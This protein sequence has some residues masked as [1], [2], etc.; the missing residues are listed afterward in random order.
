MTANAAAD[1]PESPAR[2]IV[3]LPPLILVVDD[4]KAQRELITA[5]L[6]PD[7]RL[8]TAASVSEAVIK[9]ELSPPAL[10]IMD[11]AMPAASGIEGLQR[12]RDIYPD[13]PVV[14]LTGHADLEIA[15]QA[16]QLGAIEYIL[17]PFEPADLHALVLRLAAGTARRDESLPAPL[18]EIPYALQRR[19]AANVDLWRSRLP[20]VSS[21]NRLTAVLD[22]GCAIEAKVL[23]L[24][25]HTVQ[26]EVYDPN[27]A[28]DPG[29]AIERLQVWV[30]EDCAYDGPAEMSKV[31]A[32]GLNR[33]CE[34]TMH[35]EWT[36]V[37]CATRSGRREQL[38]EE[39]RGFIARWRNSRGI[40]P[41]FMLAVAGAEA[42]FRDLRDWMPKLELSW[43]AEGPEEEHAAMN[44]LLD[45][46]TPVMNEVL[47]PFEAEARRVPEEFMGIHAEYLRA[48]LHPLLLCSPFVHRCFTKPLGFPGDY[49]IMNRMLGEPFE[50]EGLFARVINA[51]V[52]RSAAGDAYRHRVQF[53]ENV[54][55]TE[56]A[57]VAADR[58]RTCQVLS[59]GCGAASEVQQFIRHDTNCEHASFTLLDFSSDAIRYAREQIAAAAE[60]S[61][62]PAFVTA[63]EFSVQQMLAAGGRLLG[64]PSRQRAGMLE[65]G[66]YDV[67]YCAGLFDYLSDRICRRLLEIFWVLGAPGSII[68]ASN[69]APVNPIRA[70]MDYV[71]DWR[72]IYRDEPTVRALAAN[73]TLDPDAKTIPAPGGVEVFLQ[74][75]KPPGETAGADSES[76]SNLGWPV[77]LDRVA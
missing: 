46:I 20:T 66:R 56:T 33:I 16:I 8:D 76:G 9:A 19:L 12:L 67:I 18:S 61:R 43:T 27:L 65:R 5:V 31:I 6:A 48:S 30:G 13:L 60:G 75:R 15:R 51:W 2:E 49:G 57:R 38:D 58:G 50:G 4:E 70:F 39:A 52:I 37:P 59:L 42:F 77:T 71:L 25:R 45:R 23:R 35:G 24:S 62:R 54:L 29:C 10:V 3:T 47:A 55:S 22:A 21:E 53:L 69:F 36:G 14:I 11:Y 40:R 72:L 17:K 73:D 68:V 74:M 34:F 7:C 28:L 44:E 41:Q 63:V 1:S 64:N 32:T 26:A